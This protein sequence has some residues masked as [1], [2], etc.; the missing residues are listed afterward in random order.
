MEVMFDLEV[1]A[2]D[3]AAALGLGFHRVGTV[4][5]HPAFVGMMRDLI[6]E[7]MTA[8]PDRPALG[9]RGPSH[10]ICPLNCCLIGSGCP[11]TPLAAA[12]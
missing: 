11:A 7:R 12:S 3:R 5:T 9:L 1:E 4:G 10:D 8:F 6:V 2:R